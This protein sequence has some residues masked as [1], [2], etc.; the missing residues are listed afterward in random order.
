MMLTEETVEDIRIESIRC[1]QE[2]KRLHSRYVAARTL[3]DIETQIQSL[4][5]IRR[6]ARLDYHATNDAKHDA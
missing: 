2:S 3:L 1:E 4:K 6:R 5:E